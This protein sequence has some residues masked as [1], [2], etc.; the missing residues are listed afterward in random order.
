MACNITNARMVDC[1]DQVGGIKRIFFMKWKSK[2]YDLLEFDGTDTSQ[3]KSLDAAD[4]ETYT[5][6]AYDVRPNTASL[7]TTINSSP[8]NGTTFFESTLNVVLQKL[9]VQDQ[10][11]LDL[12]IYGRNIV[13]VLDNNNNCF[14][15][16]YKDGCDV[17]GGSMATG[18]AKGDMSGYTLDIRGQDTALPPF[19]KAS[20]GE[21]NLKY[22][23]DQLDD[24]A[25]IS[26]TNPTYS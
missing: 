18:T 12:L 14:P 4:T 23:F 26:V 9:T 24:N 8:E 7:T 16:G 6:I 15:I 21:E 22:P 25:N 17:T 20:A 5:M 19:I 2:L 10:A 11:E 1:K 3:I 13:W